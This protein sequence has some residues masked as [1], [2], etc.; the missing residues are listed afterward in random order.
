MSLVF[1]IRCDGCDCCGETSL[2]KY[3]YAH[4]IR[5]RLKDQGWKVSQPGG[6]DYCLECWE[7]IKEV[8]DEELS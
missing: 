1:E 8:C 4:K 7:R 5:L 2:N 3:D 6:K